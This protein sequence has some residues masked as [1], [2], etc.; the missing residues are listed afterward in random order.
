MTPEIL[1]PAGSPESLKYALMYG[2]DAVYLAGTSFGMRSA[3]ANFTDEQLPAAVAQAHAAGAKVYLTCNTVA[4]ENELEPLSRFIRTAADAG[5]DA[6]IVSDLGVF[7]MIRRIAPDTAIHIST[8]AGVAN[9]ASAN[10][11]H[12]MGASRVVLARELT[13][14]EIAAIRANTPPE[15]ELEAFVHGSMCVSFSG[16]CLLSNYLTGRDANRGD[17]AQPCRWKYALVEETRPGQYFPIGEDEHGAHILNSRDMCMIEH[18]PE[19]C[20]AGITSFKIE[21]R[22]K[23]SYYAAVVTNAYRCA[24]DE[25]LRWD[26]AGANGKFELPEW[27]AREVM[28]VSHREYSTGFYLGGEPGQVYHNGGYVRQFEVVGVV[29]GVS[30]GLLTASQRNRFF[31]GD[32]L[33]LL[34]PGEPPERLVADD[35]R[36]ADGEPIE[37]TPHPNMLFTLPY[38]DDAPKGAILRREKS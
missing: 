8:Q 22:A 15:L 1:S 30:G 33:E 31:R 28:T 23:S 29:E 18:I 38:D 36:S 14:E 4:R 20:L 24:V 12:G 19:L 34:R 10:M 16:R 25:Y 32:T 2:A 35:L 21:G 26:N 3:P 11:L 37:A 27:I 17:C 13:L 9:S 5:I 6:F 7:D